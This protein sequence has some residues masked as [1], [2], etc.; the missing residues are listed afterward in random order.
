MNKNVTIIGAGGHAKVIA[1]IIYKSGDNIYGFLDDKKE[2]GTVIIKQLN[3]KVIGN[4][5]YCIKLQQEIPDMNF[6][7]AIGKNETR[8]E[9]AEKYKELNFYTAIHPSSQ[10][11]LD[12]KIG[13]GT[14]VMANTSINS[15]TNIGKHSIINTGAVIEHDNLLEDYVHISP[16]VTLCGTVKIGEMTHVGAGTTI[17]NNISVCKKC[18]LGAGSVVVKN[19]ND[20]DTYIGVPAKKMI[21]TKI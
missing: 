16:N 1:D 3:C 9:I 6:I 21:N 7:I 17:K 13:E 19:I 14:V 20:S 18:I 5:D 8:R 15:S 4:V 2:V 11:S 12:V 10:I